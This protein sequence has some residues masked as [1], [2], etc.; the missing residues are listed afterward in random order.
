MHH[1]LRISLCV[2]IA[3][4]M[5]TGLTAARAQQPLDAKA[6]AAWYSGAT[7]EGTTSEGNPIRV[8]HDPAGIAR[9]LVAGQ[10]A[11]SGAWKIRDDGAVCVDWR[12]KAWGSNP[13]YWIKDDTDGHWKLERVDD[14]R[15]FIRVRRLEGNHYNM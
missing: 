5:A 1:A 9:G 10:Y 8:F 11:N 6:A 2:A 7:V 14:A 12:D 3:T 4:A 15:S 13:C